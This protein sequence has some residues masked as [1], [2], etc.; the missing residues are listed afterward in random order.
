VT[1]HASG[2]R[3]SPTAAFF[4]ALSRKGTEPLLK[5][6]SGTIRFDLRDGDGVEHWSVAIDKGIV[7][8][9]HSRKRADAVVRLERSMFDR[10]VV[11]KENAMA[12]TLRGELVP[13]GDLSLMILFQRAFGGPA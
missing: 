8:V 5:S 6:A 2:R 1:A 10:M 9:S 4:D 7:E 3:R 12:A 13:E 11:G